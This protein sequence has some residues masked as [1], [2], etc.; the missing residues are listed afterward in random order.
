[1]KIS[2]YI[3]YNLL[4]NNNI[5][6][7]DKYTKLIHFLE[8][9]EKYFFLDLSEDLL[10]NENICN[11]FSNINNKI[12]LISAPDIDFPP[13]KKPY[14]YDKYFNTKI[15]PPNYNDIDYYE[16]IETE[17]INIIEKNNLK[18]IAH[19]VSIN[20]DNIINIPIGIFNRFNHYHLKK[21]EKTI[22]CYANFGIPCDRWNGNPR[23]DLINILKNKPFVLQENIKTNDRNSMSH[24]HF[25]DMISR[26]KFT[27]CPRGCGIDT[28]RLW[29]TICL[30]SIP[31]VDKYDGHEQF[32]DLP[33]LFVNSYE[34]ISE[35]FLNE[36]Y[37]EFLEK[38][39]CYEKL[40]FEYWA[41]KIY[42]LPIQLEPE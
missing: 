19:S 35:D 26:S 13:P 17:L 10:E 11:I 12:I 33:I 31:I 36:K 28:Y 1:M 20:H 8:K 32:H 39:F 29:D 2:E 34:I 7:L 27:L 16:K 37:A 22:L 15:L 3:H 23:K 38:D 40:L 30:G 21:N 9:C 42:N 5:I 25:Y 6:T 41:N 18:V 4:S 24:D 14:S